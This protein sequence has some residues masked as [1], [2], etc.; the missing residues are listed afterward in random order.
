MVDN[1][2]AYIITEK[3]KWKTKYQACFWLL[4]WATY[5]HNSTTLY[6]TKKS[7]KPIDFG[8]LNMYSRKNLKTPAHTYRLRKV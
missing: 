2:C 4:Q 3:F 1:Y 7:P 5:I 6:P 8:D